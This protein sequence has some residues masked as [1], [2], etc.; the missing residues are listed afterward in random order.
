VSELGALWAAEGTKWESGLLKVFEFLA[1]MC[2]CAV[3]PG[4][5]GAEAGVEGFGDFAA[6]PDNQRNAILLLQQQG[7]SY[8]EIAESLD[9]SLSSVK[10]WIHRARTHLRQELLTPPPFTFPRC[11]FTCPKGTQFTHPSLLSGQ[12]FGLPSPCF[13]H[14]VSHPYGANRRRFT[15]YALLALRPTFTP[16]NFHTFTHQL[17]WSIP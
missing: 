13:S 5:D 11:S 12:T 8:D 1:Q 3:Y 15:I 6:L 7:L 17:R 10:T 9:A 16:S 4:L 2:A 14:Y